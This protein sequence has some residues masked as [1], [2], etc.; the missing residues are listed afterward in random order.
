[1]ERGSVGVSYWMNQWAAF[2]PAYQNLA[3]NAC[4]FELWKNVW[5]DPDKDP[6]KS[7]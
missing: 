6:F 3:P 1:M 7:S 5:Y 2:N 4:L